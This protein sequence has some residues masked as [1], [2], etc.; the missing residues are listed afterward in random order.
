MIQSSKSV[1]IETRAVPSAAHPTTPASSGGS[2][3]E[4]SRVGPMRGLAV[5]L[6]DDRLRVADTAAGHRTVP[7]VCNPAKFLR[8]PYTHFP[9]DNRCNSH[10]ITHPRCGDRSG[11]RPPERQHALA[12]G[13]AKAVAGVRRDDLDVRGLSSLCARTDG[14]RTLLPRLPRHF[15]SW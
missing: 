15:L 13:I 11:N 2:I 10:R 6:A 5:T 1:S 14:R 8:T 9:V 12:V 7:G 3:D 4:Q